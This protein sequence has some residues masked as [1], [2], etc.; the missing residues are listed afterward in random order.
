MIKI[1]QSVDSIYWVLCGVGLLC[2]ILV[3]AWRQHLKCK[4]VGSQWRVAHWLTDPNFWYSIAFAIL[5]AFGLMLAIAVDFKLGGIISL[6]I[7]FSS[8]ALWTNLIQAKKTI[9]QIRE[10]GN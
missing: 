9:S 3:K 8:N 7:G 4:K 10:Q 6:T 2:H 1:L 5:T